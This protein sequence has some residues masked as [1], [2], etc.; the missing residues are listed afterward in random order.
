MWGLYPIPPIPIATL[1]ISIWD[2]IFP[3]SVAPMALPTFQ[4]ANGDPLFKQLLT[5]GGFR[6]NPLA[7]PDPTGKT[8]FQFTLEQ[9]TGV[10]DWTASGQLI[11]SSPGASLGCNDRSNG[12]IFSNPTICNA[13]QFFVADND[14]IVN[15][16]DHDL[17]GLRQHQS[18]RRILR[19]V[20]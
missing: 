20:Q 9:A 14:V 12:G 10:S 6:Y 13:E 19:S 5:N 16:F 4:I 7:P 1:D 8:Q 17:G 3:V 2:K 11:T 15:L 18:R